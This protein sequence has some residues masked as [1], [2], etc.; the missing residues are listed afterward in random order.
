MRAKRP[1]AH[2]FTLIL[3]CVL[4]LATL[5]PAAL[6]ATTG[7][8]S[9]PSL[10]SPVPGEPRP[11][12]RSAPN[13]PESNGPE[14]NGSESTGSE[15][16]G[17]PTSGSESGGAEAGLPEVTLF[18]NSPYPFGRSG[19]VF[20]LYPFSHVSS[21]S[22][23][24][25]DQGVDLGGDANQCGHGLVEVAVE[26]GTIV[27]EGLAGFGRWAPVLL[28]E[29]G[30]DTGRYIYY[31]HAAPALVSVGTHVSAGEPIADVGCGS[32]GISSAPHLEIG[33]LPQG[34]A[35]PEYMPAFGQTS[36]ET[37]AKLTSAYRAA[38]SSYE[39]RKAALHKARRS[40]R[41]R[42]RKAGSARARHPH[43]A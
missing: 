42:R 2:T 9:A 31:G 35:G 41:R 13:G 10:V 21:P 16:N 8:V 38:L 11:P 36:K 27:H 37:H 30:P 28:V 4:S 14:S 29:K 1:R 7:G 5:A 26:E 40:V 19:W 39:A 25:L 18:P 24:S 17:S 43:A 12:A 20:P 23:W 34:V 22:W 6:A 33:M 32:V 15:S 3:I